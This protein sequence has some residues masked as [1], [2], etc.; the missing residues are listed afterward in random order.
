MSKKMKQSTG[1]SD[2]NSEPIFLN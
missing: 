1:E 2:F